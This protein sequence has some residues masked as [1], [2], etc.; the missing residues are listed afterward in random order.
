[1]IN[2]PFWGTPNFWKHPN[3]ESLLENHLGETLPGHFWNQICSLTKPT[4][5]DERSDVFPQR[6]WGCE[7]DEVICPEAGMILNKHG[8]I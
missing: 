4:S 2:P 8:Q 6:F 1:M 3:L 7:I 5:S